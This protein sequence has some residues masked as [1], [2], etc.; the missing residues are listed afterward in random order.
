M[1]D[2]DQ[3]SARVD[4]RLSGRD[5]F[6]GRLAS[7]GDPTIPRAQLLKPFPQYT[8]VSFYRNN[9]GTTFYQGGQ[10]GLRQRFARSLSYTL[11]YT[12]STLKDDASSVFDAA[13]LTAPVANVP[14]ADSFNRAR[15]RDDSTGD[16]PHLFVGSLVWDLPFGAGRA[17]DPKRLAGAL[18]DDW[19]LVTLQSGVPVAVIQATN[20]NAFAG[21]GT[22]RPSLVGRPELPADQRTAD[23]WF[24]TAAFAVTPPFAI[25]SASRN[26][27]RGSSCR[28]VD[29]ALMRRV[30]VDRIAIELRAEV[31]NLL[32]TP[33]LGAPAAVLGTAN[34][35]SI[36]TALDPRVIQL[37]VKV[38]F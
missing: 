10:V 5:G 38:G 4:Q 32:N 11:S 3:W 9:V 21:F 13:I 2:Q 31:F 7:L 6:F 26:P 8:A 30:P 27:V 20:F 23:R 19:T 37:A 22:Q 16:M 33:N 24:D 29:V 1:N 36:T 35:G 12:R 25:G 18:L 15:E 14:A 28:N 17:H 34:F